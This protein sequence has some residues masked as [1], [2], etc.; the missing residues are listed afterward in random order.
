ME[1]DAQIDSLSVKL[2]TSQPSRRQSRSSLVLTPKRHS[3]R[4][5]KPRST[6][7][8]PR[9]AER[10]R[11]ITSMKQYASLEDH[12]R[13]M[14][15]DHSPSKPEVEMEIEPL[16]I[17]TRPFSWHPSSSR[18]SRF[19]YQMSQASDSASSHELIV[20]QDSS[21]FTAKPS[22]NDISI[23]YPSMAAINIE[24]THYASATSFSSPTVPEDR[25]SS[26]EE[27]WASYAGTSMAITSEPS[28]YSISDNEPTS[29]LLPDY[30][31]QTIDPPQYQAVQQD[32]LPIQ[33]P[34]G[35]QQESADEEE[36]E[37]ER[38]DSNVLVGMGLYDPPGSS[39]F[40]LG[41]GKCL[42]LEEEW[43]P[44]ELPSD[45]DDDEA[46]NEAD[47]ESSEEEEEAPEPPKAAEKPWTLR[48]GVVQP[49]SNLAGQSFFF[50][51]DESITSEWWYQQFKQP[52]A[53]DAGIG[54]GWLHNV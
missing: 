53:Q 37:L 23:V 4:V 6:Y 45:D 5:E 54:Y 47:Q 33:H 1:V 24:N 20:P 19:S 28:S 35:E 49:P 29:W 34:A 40:A 2:T 15:G 44:P 42:K 13:S 7:Q 21:S 36:N 30:A 27:V 39:A 41:E 11:T 31:Q 10:R 26:Q 9:V 22:S 12:Y 17:I 25:L 18:F 14:F 48:T 38:Q 8:S 43:E 3:A 52:A 16:D 32:F 46:D 50:D 51:D